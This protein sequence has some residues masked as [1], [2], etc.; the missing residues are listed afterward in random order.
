MPAMPTEPVPSLGTPALRPRAI[1]RLTAALV[2]FAILVIVLLAVWVQGCA[3]DDE[4]TTYGTYLAEIGDVD[5][6]RRLAPPLAQVDQEVGAPGERL[7]GGVL[8]EERRRLEER[9]RAPV[10]EGRQEHR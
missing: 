3:G 5:Q 8:R 1:A 2:A 4:Q 6:H 10:L 9:R 7:R